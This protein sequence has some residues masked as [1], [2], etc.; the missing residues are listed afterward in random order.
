MKGD[1][2][3]KPFPSDDDVARFLVAVPYG[4]DNA[5]TG[6]ELAAALGLADSDGELLPHWDRHIRALREAAINSGALVCADDRG[7]FQPA[8]REETDASTG[9][10]RKQIFT[11][12]ASL[13]AEEELIARIF[14]EGELEQPLLFADLL[15]NTYSR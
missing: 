15:Q 3:R 2:S 6:R 8:S 10:R 4:R 1:P 7:Y 9:R 14:P 13:K 5:L 12:L 11:T